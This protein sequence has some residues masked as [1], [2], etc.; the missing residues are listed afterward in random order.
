MSNENIR[1]LTDPVWALC[2]KENGSGSFLM[3]LV[4]VGLCGLNT[5]YKYNN[6]IKHLLSNGIC[7]M[8]LWLFT[9]QTISCVMSTMGDITH[10]VHTDWPCCP[11]WPGCWYLQVWAALPPSRRKRLSLQRRWAPDPDHWCH[12]PGSTAGF[13]R[14]LDRWTTRP[15]SSQGSLTHTHMQSYVHWIHDTM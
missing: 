5:Y 1:H 10:C 2:G 7:K 4:W 12:C 6:V 11:G 15:D 9:E 3:I 13:W 8:K 14:T